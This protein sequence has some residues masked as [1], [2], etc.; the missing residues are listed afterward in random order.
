MATF[1]KL[2]S[3]NCRVLI[4]R[5]KS[6]AS[7][8]FR[9]RRDAELWALDME[10]RVD[11]NESVSVHRPK[12]IKTFASLVDLHISD[13]H[14]VQKPLRRSKAYALKKLKVEL[15]KTTFDRLNREQLIIYGRKRTKE[16]AGQSFR[17]RN[18]LVAAKSSYF[19]TM[20]DR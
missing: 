12:H 7:E 15:G 11:C 14:E 10:R 3:G 13:M 9:R 18:A 20:E 6:Y 16:G 5:K 8:T 1:Q 19:L 17:N 4:R 2:P